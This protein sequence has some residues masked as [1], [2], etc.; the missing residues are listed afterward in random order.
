MAENKKIDSSCDVLLI[1]AGIM[2]ATLGMFIKMLEPKWRV[3]LYE[4]LPSAACESSD[5]WNN[6]GTGHSALCELNYTPQKADGSIDITKALAIIEDFELSKQFWASL[7]E[8]GSLDSHKFIR[9]VPHMSFVHEH[10]IPFLRKRF[11][12]LQTSPLFKNMV[13][14]EDRA[15][16]TQWIPLMMEHRNPEQKIAATYSSLGTDVNF[17]ELARQLLTN[18][19]KRG[20][21][22]H[23]SQ[24]I[25][26]IRRVDDAWQVKIK[27]VKSKKVTRVAAKFVFI[28]AGGGSLHLLQKSGIP[29]ANGYGGFPVAGQW[30]VCED[31]QIASKHHTKVYGKA[32]VGAPPMSVPHLDKRFIDGKH[33]LLFGPFAGFSTKFL[34]QGKLTDLFATIRLSNLAPMMT[35]G[36]KNWGLE[37]YLIQQVAQSFANRMKQLRDFYPDAKDSDWRLAIA[38]QRV[39]I[40]KKSAEKGGVLQFGTEVVH[41]ADGSLAALLGASPGASTAVAIMLNVLRECFPEEMQSKWEAAIKKWIP[42]YGESL[43]DNPELLEK[44]RE[45]SASALGLT[46]DAPADAAAHTSV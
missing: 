7:V 12:A 17:G 32:S 6:A 22:L 3:Q 25:L 41:S 29:E 33:A 30:L 5:A 28:G 19:E 4:R 21:E 31:E 1:G 15:Q 43:G 44:T 27:H 40:I 16:I 24:E 35:V 9:S 26:D 11:A 8:R 34:K 37:K 42:S 46:I 39:Q 18:L 10:D 23:Y 14:S 2:S 20:A 38:G 45:W 36:M 13:Y